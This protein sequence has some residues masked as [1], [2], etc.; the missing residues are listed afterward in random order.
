[1]NWKQWFLLFFMQICRVFS[2][3]FVVAVKYLM[4]Y[5]EKERY[6]LPSTCRVHRDNDIYREQEEHKLRSDINEWR[7]GFCKKAFYEEKYLDKHFDSRH[8]NLLNAVYTDALLLKWSI[9]LWQFILFWGLLAIHNLCAF[10]S[11][12]MVNVCRIF[13]ERCIVILL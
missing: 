8:Y 1:M 11:R 6:Q 3:I 7:C 12:V 4:P 2:L 9:F 13:V 5:V 10:E